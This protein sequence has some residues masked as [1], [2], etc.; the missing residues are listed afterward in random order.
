MAVDAQKSAMHSPLALLDAVEQREIIVE[1]QAIFPIT[2]A[3]PIG[4]EALIRWDHP[5]AGRLAPADF[6]PCDMGNDIGSVL[7]NYVLEEATRQCSIWRRGGLDV[8]VSVNIA[9]GRM[10]DQILPPHIATLLE[11]HHLAPNLLTVEITESRCTTGPRGIARALAGLASIGVRLSL[12]DFGTGESSLSRLRHLQFDEIKIDR[13]FVTDVATCTT[14]RNIVTF[15]TDLGHSLGM[16]VVA[17]GIE[18]QV[19]QEVLIHLGVDR[20]QG[21]HCHRPAVAACIDGQFA[22]GRGPT[23]PLTS[24]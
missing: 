18:D 10:A 5:V 14:D 3:D 4:F 7:T 20:A 11:R 23:R 8:G 2:G 17:E 22:V 1:Y 21:F 9:P 15:I 6:L 13:S 24:P 16:S 19:C 12:D